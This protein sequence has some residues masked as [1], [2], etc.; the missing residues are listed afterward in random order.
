MQELKDRV[1]S[2]ILSKKEH[3]CLI[4]EVK[5]RFKRHDITPTL[6][7]LE[8]DNVIVSCKLGRRQYYVHSMFGYNFLKKQGLRKWPHPVAIKSL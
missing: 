1:A 2:F 5:R 3:G 6:L 8:K 4:R 7:V